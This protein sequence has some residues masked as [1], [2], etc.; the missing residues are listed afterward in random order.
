MQL[1][2]VL[3]PLAFLSFV[4][5]LVTACF[6]TGVYGEDVDRTTKCIYA[7]EAAVF[8]FSIAI[9]YLAYA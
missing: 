3:A 6:S 4:C 1:Y 5:M 2:H 7:V 8:L 9:L